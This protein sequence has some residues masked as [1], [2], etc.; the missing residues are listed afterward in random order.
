MTKIDYRNGVSIGEIMVYVPSLLV[1]CFLAFKHGMGRSSGW[2]FL[3]FFCLARIIGPSMQLATISDPRNTSLYTGSAILNNVG[4]SPLEMAAFGFLSRL[5]TSI[6]KTHKPIIT[7][8]MIRLV[9]LVVVVGLVLGIV[10]G[11]NA[12]NE[13]VKTIRE[14]GSYHPGTLNK[15]GTALIIVSYAFLATFTAIT[16]PSVQY[17]ESGEKR[18][19]L[20]VVLSLPFLLIRLIYSCL[21]T[22]TTKSE[23]NLLTGSVTVLLCLSLIE[24][25]LVVVMFEAMGLTLQKSVKEEHVEVGRIHKSPQLGAPTQD[26]DNA[27]LRIAKKTIIGRIVMA[28][29]PRKEK[30]IEM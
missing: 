10:G 4:L 18:L 22:Y 11:V 23:F 16:Y 5:V 7:P 25:F 28:I 13:Y 14:G 20:V 9:Q 30:D 1:A 27:V 6:S 19:F 15:A 26:S 24:E 8:R 21:S 17:A 3:I 29:I 12:S 2:I